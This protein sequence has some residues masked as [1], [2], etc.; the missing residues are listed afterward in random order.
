MATINSFEDL[1]IWKKA[2]VLVRNVYK[3]T[4]AGPFAKDFGLRDQLR[5]ATVSIVSNIAEGFERSGN[6]EF[7]HFLYLAKGSAGEARTQ[8][9]VALDLLYLPDGLFK[10]LNAAVLMLSKQVGAFI[11]YLEKAP[12]KP[13]RDKPS[14]SKPSNF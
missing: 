10:E 12:P 11:N 5:R 1:E 9:Y 14:G 6:R 13:P 3:A 4:A 2:R 8:L 7:I